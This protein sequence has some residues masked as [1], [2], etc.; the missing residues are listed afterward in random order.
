[1]LLRTKAD[2]VL[3]EGGK[4][5]GISARNPQGTLD[6]YADVVILSAGGQGTPPILQRSGSHAGNGLFSDPLWLVVGSA[7]VRG[8]KFDVPM[9]AGVNLEE[10][11][12][13]LTDVL[14]PPMFYAGMFVF[15]GVRGWASL[16]KAHHE[17]PKDAGDHGQGEGRPRRAG[18]PG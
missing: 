17:L 3:T 11:G 14:A 7:N 9:T 5:V 1:M 13:V 10:D 18:E 15:N 8:S 12:I 16:P 4:A 2:K 6:V